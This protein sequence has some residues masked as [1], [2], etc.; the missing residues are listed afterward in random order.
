MSAG[1]STGCTRSSRSSTT[2][3]QT[4]GGW[5]NPVR[6][7]TYR[8]SNGSTASCTIVPPSSPVISLRIGRRGPALQRVDAVARR[9]DDDP[10]GNDSNA[11]DDAVAFGHEHDPPVGPE[12]VDGQVDGHDPPQ[13]R[14]ERGRSDQGL[15]AGE[16]EGRRRV[17]PDHD[18]SP[19]VGRPVEQLD[20]R[21]APTD[22]RLHEQPATVRRGHHT[23]P[24]L[25]GRVLG[26]DDR[27]V[28]TVVTERVV[29]DGAVV[30]VALRVA[31]VE[32]AETV[33]FPGHTAGPTVCDPVVEQRTR[34]PSRRPGA[35]SSRSRPR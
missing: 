23:R 25:R 22:R 35:R 18:R 33:W 14:A 8:D 24:R 19:L 29:M 13:R 3:Q 12:I 27:I 17:D 30:L 1:A 34:R 4:A 16:R 20:I 21:A 28:G 15:V 10:V 26:P 5:S 32:E 31:G 6:R 7:R 11:G 2:T 9:G